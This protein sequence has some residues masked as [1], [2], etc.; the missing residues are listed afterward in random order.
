MNS[1]EQVNQSVERAYQWA[2]SQFNKTF[3]RPSIK[4]D[5]A[6]RA[7]GQVIYEKNLIRINTKLL[8][9]NP[10][11]MINQTAPHEAFH[12]IARHVY[13]PY[14]S[15]HGVQWQSLMRG[16]G[17]NPNRYHSLQT[18]PARNRRKVS[19]S[20]FCR[21]EIKIDISVHNRIVKGSDYFCKKCQHKITPKINQIVINH[22][23][24]LVKILM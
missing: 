1:I 13:G 2:E 6:G 11:Y 17:L 22:S 8:N 5:L 7:A 15:G 12:L 18:T 14:I 4:F 16:Y 9:Q 10:D 24:G 23:N 19:Y 3:P 20:C 21:D